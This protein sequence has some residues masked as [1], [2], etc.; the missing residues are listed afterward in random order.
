MRKN[1]IFCLCVLLNSPIPSV[2]ASGEEVQNFSIEKVKDAVRNFSSCVKSERAVFDA[3][4][5]ICGVVAENRTELRGYLVCPVLKGYIFARRLQVD[6]QRGI[7]LYRCAG[8]PDVVVEMTF[9]SGKLMVAG[10][11]ELLP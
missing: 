10:I 7:F 2:A 3:D 1:I 8:H 4:Y 6:A 11:G 9:D 5:K